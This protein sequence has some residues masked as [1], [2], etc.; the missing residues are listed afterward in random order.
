MRSFARR[1][2]GY[3]DLQGVCAK[4]AQELPELSYLLRQLMEVG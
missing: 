4:F 3:K 1:E 2:A